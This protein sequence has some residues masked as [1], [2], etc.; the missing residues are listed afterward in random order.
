[1]WPIIWP[2]NIRMNLRRSQQCLVSTPK[3]HL[4]KDMKHSVNRGNNT[5][6]PCYIILLQVH[7]REKTPP[8]RL[9]HWTLGLGCLFYCYFSLLNSPNEKDLCPTFIH[10]YVQYTIILTYILKVLFYSL[11]ET[12]QTLFWAIFGL[13]DLENFEL[14]GIKE[15]SRFTGLLMFGSYSVINII[16]L[17]NL[18]IAMMNHSYQA[19][20]VSSVSKV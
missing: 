20:S 3:Q 16:V 5:I 4:S 9:Q 6:V 19:I 8:W 15:F 14:T 12:S 2:G 18:L 13:I 17:L 11:W 10:M 1:M 7:M